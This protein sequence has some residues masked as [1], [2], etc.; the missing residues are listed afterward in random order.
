MPKPTLRYPVFVPTK[1]RAE[2]PYTLKVFLEMGLPFRAVVEEQERDQ[3]AAVVG[4]ARLLVLPF[5]DRGLVATRNW[6]W[7]QAQAEGVS[8]FWT[9]DDNIWRFDRLNRNRKVAVKTPAMFCAMEDFVDRYENIAIA[10][11]NYRNFAKQKQRIPPF[12]LNTRVYS[13]MLIQTDLRAPDGHAYRNRGFYNDDTDLCLQV[14]KDGW[15]TVL[16]NAF[17]VSKK[18]TMTVKGGMTPHYQGDGR[19][20]MAQEI[21]TRHPDVARVSWKWGRWQH[22]VDYRP[23]R[24]NRL[25]LKPG[26]VVQPDND[27]H[28][29]RLQSLA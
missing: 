20:K 2:T 24:K 4:A 13:N 9:F 22:H 18:T 17:L 29:M 26:I 25:R 12:E 11:C 27:E 1:G 21:T 15:V 3:Y 5:R 16:F 8:R 28:G 10:G 6:I 23:F 7:D 14:L 19:L